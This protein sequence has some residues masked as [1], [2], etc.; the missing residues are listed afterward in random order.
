ML[1]KNFALQRF[2]F[3]KISNSNPF[4]FRYCIYY[5][6]VAINF[7]VALYG[8]WKAFKVRLL[9]FMFLFIEDNACYKLRGIF[10]IML[11]LV[12]MLFKCQ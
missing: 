2:H 11:Y 10:A 7:D 4:I 1:K 8:L 9:S 5:L 3:E 12:C 6:C